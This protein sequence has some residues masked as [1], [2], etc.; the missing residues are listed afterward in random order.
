MES[1]KACPP[2]ATP[3]LLANIVAVGGCALFGGMESRLLSEIRAL[4]PNDMDVSVTVPKKCAFIFC[5]LI[6]SVISYHFS[7]QTYSWE[8]G[9]K[10]SQNP[11]FL[12]M[13]MSRE[14]YEE[15]GV[16]GAYERFD[17]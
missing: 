5:T 4:A 15:E 6:I 11:E 1:I 17:I 16:R 3:H 7:P 10:I 14:E 9:V 2:E 13:C 8:G 12:G